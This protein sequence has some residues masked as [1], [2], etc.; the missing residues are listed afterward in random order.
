[1][2]GTEGKKTIA[3]RAD[4]D[5]LPIVEE[6][7]NKPYIS[8]NHGVSHACGHDGHTA[9]LLAVANWMSNNRHEVK[10]NIKFIFQSS[11]EASPSGAEQLVKEGVLNGVDSIL[12]FISFKILKW[13][14]SD[15]PKGQRWRH[16]MILIL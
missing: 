6:G 16:A 12:E 13:G 15:L 11:E 2:K 14:R 4:M 5:A 3:L 9:I 1:M 7:E 10:N 8:K